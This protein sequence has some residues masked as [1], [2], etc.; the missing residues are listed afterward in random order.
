[1]P[2]GYSVFLNE[3]KGELKLRKSGDVV[4]ITAD[5]G[6]YSSDKQGGAKVLLVKPRYQKVA[7]RPHMN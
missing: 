3:V 4:V 6:T 5:K 2:D 7:V 1:M